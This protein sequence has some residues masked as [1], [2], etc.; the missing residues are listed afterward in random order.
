M[1]MI[2]SPLDRGKKS[3]NYSISFTTG[4]Q[5]NKKPTFTNVS[6]LFLLWS[7]TTTVKGSETISLR[8]ICP[9]FL[10]EHT[11]V[12]LTSSWHAY[13]SYRLLPTT[14]SM[15]SV[16]KVTNMASLTRYGNKVGYNP[17]FAC[18]NTGKKEPHESVAMAAFH[19]RGLILHY[20]N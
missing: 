13:H 2:P 15:T 20:F 18:R 7:Y 9:A 14:L 5:N 16:T 12:K 19:S 17:S 4:A 8:T 11:W 1:Q 6:M 3:A 10:H